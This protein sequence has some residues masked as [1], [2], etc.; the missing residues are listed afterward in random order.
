MKARMQ[1]YRPVDRKGRL[2]YQSGR[3]PVGLAIDDGLSL[4][5]DGPDS[6]VQRIVDCGAM[7]VIDMGAGEFHLVCPHG[8]VQLEDVAWTIVTS[9]GRV[10]GTSEDMTKLGSIPLDPVDDDG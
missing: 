7:P 5:L 8:T 9:D 1:I 6:I 4:E 2:A 10:L 3:K